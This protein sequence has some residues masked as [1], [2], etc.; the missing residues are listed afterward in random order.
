MMYFYI[1]KLF[2]WLQSCY[3]VVVPLICSPMSVSHVVPKYPE[4]QLQVNL[5]D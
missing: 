1:T 2:F 4:A 5:S 3:K